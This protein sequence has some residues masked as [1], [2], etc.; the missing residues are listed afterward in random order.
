MTF[1]AGLLDEDRDDAGVGGG[2]ADNEAHGDA[3]SYPP[4]AL[5]LTDSCAAL[6]WHNIAQYP[7]SITRDRPAVWPEFRCQRRLALDDIAGALLRTF[8]PARLLL[9]CRRG[10]DGSEWDLDL[11]LAGSRNADRFVRSLGSLLPDLEVN[12]L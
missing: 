3:G 9:R 7:L 1:T 11:L 12:Y 6:L 4:R 10:G 8:D 5:V 2:E